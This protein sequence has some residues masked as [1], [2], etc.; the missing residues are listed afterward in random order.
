MKNTQTV[1]TLAFAF[2]LGVVAPIFTHA[3]RV[4]AIEQPIAPVTS[5]TDLSTSSKTV[6]ASN[7]EE[8]NNALSDAT[9]TDIILGG[10]LT[11]L[12]ASINRSVNIDLA[13][14]TIAN[15]GNATIHA[16]KGNIN[17]TSS[18]E[19]GAI[20]ALGGQYA[21]GVL[22]APTDQGANYIVLTI[23][24]QVE[25]ST[26]AS[27]GIAI[28]PN[29]STQSAYGAVVNL[30]GAIT[31]P[32]GVYINGTIQHLEQRPQ[33]HIGSTAKVTTSG[34]TDGDDTPIYAAGE[35]EWTIDAATLS[36]LAA[37]GIKAGTFTFNNTNVS[38]TGPEK[39]VSP[40]SNQI[41][42][43][44]SVFQLEH[45]SGYADNIVLNIN[46]GNYASAQSSVFYEYGEPTAARAA[47]GAA[48]I[49]INGGTFTA[50]TDPATGA[51][52]AIFAGTLDELNIEIAGG[53][54]KGTDVNEF[55]ENGYLASNLA[56]NSDGTVYRPSNHRP[57]PSTP[58]PDPATPVDPETPAEQPSTNPSDVPDT[59]SLAQQGIIS[60]VSTVA[61]LLIG[62]GFMFMFFSGKIHERQRL[63]RLA[64]I[65]HE[66]D[67][68]VE[69]I[70]DEPEREPAIER[71]VA[72]PIA[73][74]E[75]IA[76]TVDPFAPRK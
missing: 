32:Y 14:H 7:N 66:I 31:G 44:G 71:F 18:L 39:I 28:L 5:N 73:R 36:G 49:N 38:I 20:R 40:T 8:F 67:A 72:E 65:E 53:T 37:I 1:A 52:K 68:E 6:T 43:T 25:L 29:S 61:P 54:F 30:N 4:A 41:I 63:R 45:N 59:G 46:G 62:A 22:G 27:Y 12:S 35:G 57:N 76:T 34:S 60:A 75:P 50:G 51:Q 24:E 55:K 69:E 64:A 23:G 9:V 11:N 26:T 15:S 47:T 2:M 48:D 3:A 19:G 58:N 74:D 56:V 33:V 17:I 70:V 13:G 10:N 21:I 42:G 16:T